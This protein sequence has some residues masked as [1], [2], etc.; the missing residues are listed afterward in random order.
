MT[1]HTPLIDTSSPTRAH[2]TALRDTLGRACGT[3]QGIRL[4]SLLSSALN[5]DG[6]PGT[7]ATAIIAATLCAG[8]D[9]YRTHFGPHSASQVFGAPAGIIRRWSA[10][11][12]ARH[13]DFLEIRNVSPTIVARVDY[14]ALAEYI[15]THAAPELLAAPPET[16]G[17]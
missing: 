5:H 9:G 4:T 11:K 6:C 10:E 8:Q 7:E 15:H 14:T 16:A 17:R 12:R 2:E 3:P 1:A 13:A